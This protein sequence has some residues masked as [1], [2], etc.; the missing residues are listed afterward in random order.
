MLLGIPVGIR[1]V[2]VNLRNQILPQT[3]PQTMSKITNDIFHPTILTRRGKS[4]A[5]G[6]AFVRRRPLTSKTPK[7]ALGTI[8][9]G[10][11][12]GIA[13]GIVNLNIVWITAMTAITTMRNNGRGGCGCGCCI[14][15]ILLLLVL[16]LLWYGFKRWI[17][18]KCQERRIIVYFSFRGS[19]TSF[20]ISVVVVLVVLVCWMIHET[21]HAHGRGGIQIQ[22]I[23]FRSRLC[24]LN[25]GSHPKN[26]Q[27]D[28]H[29]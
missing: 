7:T 19:R 24:L 15:R 2:V 5:L 4:H 29:G 14:G 17:S 10:S 27:H 11:K 8:H 26:A 6:H 1:L 12:Q 28:E 18:C 20:W 16:F 9:G 13:R 22:G 3:H 23:G 25:F 21:P